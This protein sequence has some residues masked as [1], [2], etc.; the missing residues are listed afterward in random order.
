MKQ[1]RLLLVED[2]NN[3]GYVLDEYLSMYDFDV[4]WVRNGEEA[5]KQLQQEFYHLCILDV[6]MPKMD[7]F[8]LAQHIQKQYPQLPFIFLTARSLKID[9]LKGFKLGA[10]DY[11][12]KPIDEEE[13]IA[14]IKA[15]LRRVN[16]ENDATEES[17]CLPI[18][19]YI[20]DF[21]N[22]WLKNGA[23][24][25]QLTQKE[26]ELLLMLSQNKGQVLNR[27]EALKQLWGEADFF[28]RRSMD[29]FISR[30]R[31]YLSE[32]EKIKIVN[33]HSKGFILIDG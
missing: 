16:P 27:K 10:D 29:V 2:D 23:K 18:G 15:V 24:K 21:K 20:F 12:I 25:I 4:C 13:L 11:L 14:R 3:L 8:T 9:K 26:T 5:L 33:V 30:L 28:N 17:Y 6:M 32:D 1:A 22:H 7:G 19:S 31:K